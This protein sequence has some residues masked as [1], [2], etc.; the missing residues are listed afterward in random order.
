MYRTRYSEFLKIDFP[1]IPVPGSLALFNAL[2]NLGAELVELHLLESPKLNE[3]ITRYDGPE[4]PEV[5]RVAWSGEA[6]WL[7]GGATGRRS[8][9]TPDTARFHGVSEAVWNFRIGGYQVCEKWLKDRKG[10]TLSKGEGGSCELERRASMK[11][12]GIC[13]GLEV[14]ATLRL[15]RY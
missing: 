14:L 7:D 5:A 8:S 13:Q 2:V 1:R 11:R 9:E 3:S 4:N 15:L 12:T 6:V 10:R